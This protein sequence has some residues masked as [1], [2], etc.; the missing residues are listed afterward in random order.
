M[1]AYIAGSAASA[2][3]SNCCDSTS[4]ADVFCED[5]EST[6][7]CGDEAANDSVCRNTWDS[8]E[9]TD[10][11]VVFDA[12]HSGTLSCTDK[13]S[14]AIQ[15]TKTST[16]APH[17]IKLAKSDESEVFVQFYLNVTE[18]PANAEEIYI[19]SLNNAADS[20]RSVLLRLT[21]TATNP[22]LRI[23]YENGSELSVGST[24][25]ITVGTWYRIR[26]HWKA[27]SADPGSDGVVQFYVNDTNPTN[28]SNNNSQNLVGLYRFGN[29]N[30]ADTGTYILQI[31][32]IKVDNDTEPGACP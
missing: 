5:S 3:A 30:A 6:T 15:I 18:S 14:R 10:S 31:D 8:T 23:L 25:A 32:N 13:G 11:T 21:G 12:A 7:D 22:T 27:A 16:D 4:D 26:I 17:G 20:T 29:A 24:T 1:N 28:I 9:A 2:A 19:G